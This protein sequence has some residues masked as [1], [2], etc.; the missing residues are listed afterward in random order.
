MTTVDTTLRTGRRRR[1][2][3]LQGPSKLGAVL[4]VI[5]LGVFTLLPI[6][7]LIV[8]SLTP[9]GDAFTF[10]PRFWP[11]HLT[12]HAFTTFFGNSQLTTYFVNSV[13]VTVA[14][15]VIAIVVSS[16]CAYSLSKFRYRG[17][18]AIAY[19]VLSTQLFPSTLLV[20]A[21]YLLFNSYHL[22]NSYF[23]II[24]SYSTF[25]LPLCVFILKNYFDTI[26][27][28]L[29]EA[30]KLDGASQLAI[31]HRIILPVAK[32]GLVAAGLFAVIRS[33]NDFIIALTLAGP[34]T[35]TLPPGLVLTYLTQDQ[36]SW[37]GLM[38]ASLIVSLPVIVLFLF[39]QRHLTSGI[40]AGSIKG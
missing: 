24:L 22:L 10:P 8:T 3:P 18:T 9:D 29:I 4:T 30:A 17:R 12:L 2:S 36:S 6:Y 34:K 33:W 5:V 25:T 11:K 28:E 27:D 19:F 26:P 13:V 32:P 16:Y 15:A 40:T 21:L 1:E 31:I 39:F 23:A 20:I 14:A 38:A 7:W 37:P 35:M